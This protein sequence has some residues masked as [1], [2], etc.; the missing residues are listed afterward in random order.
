MPPRY[1]W[2]TDK[3][4]EVPTETPEEQEVRLIKEAEAAEREAWKREEAER[5]ARHVSGPY[6]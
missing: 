4:K 2:N 6:L 1:R 5:K 3:Q